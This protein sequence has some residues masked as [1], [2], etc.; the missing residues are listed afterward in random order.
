MNLE[1]NNKSKKLRVGILDSMP[2]SSC[3]P[4]YRGIVVDIWKETAVKYNLDYEFICLKIS[5]DDAIKKLKDDEIDV[6]LAEISVVSRRFDWAL[7]SRPFFVS[8]LYIYRKEK[9]N[10]LSFLFD[11]Q[12]KYIF[13]IVLFFVFL[14][15]FIFI[16]IFNIP[17]IDAFYKTILSF[18]LNLFN[19]FIN[20]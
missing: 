16:Y 13:A 18:N 4:T 7:Y 12:I 9:K 11:V 1:N 3:K 15:S 10:F 19:N 2:Y 8:E 6:I 5:Y 14:Y 20:T 17:V